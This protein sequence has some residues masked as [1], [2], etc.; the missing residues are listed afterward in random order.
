MLAYGARKSSSQY[1]T[2]SATSLYEWADRYERG[3]IAY[4]HPVLPR[5]TAHPASG[6]DK[7]AAPVLV[8]G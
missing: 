6:L 7:A 3:L 1:E 8:R 2:S 4:C 5:L